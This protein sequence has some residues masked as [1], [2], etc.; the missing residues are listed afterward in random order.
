VL[1]A[2]AAFADSPMKTCSIDIQAASEKESEV[3]QVLA[4]FKTREKVLDDK[5]KKARTTLEPKIAAL[6][7]L[8]PEARAAEEAK[9]SGEINKLQEEFTKEA[10]KIKAD[11]E[12]VLKDM[13]EKNRLLAISFAKEHGCDELHT[14]IVP[15]AI[16]D[17]AKK[18]HLTNEFVTKYNKTYPAKAAPKTP[19]P[20]APPTKK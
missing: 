18:N 5:Q 20:K 13:R 7:N 4:D 11:F 15:I 1:N 2:S 3:Q 16:S 17:R 9:L 19:A 8:K 14:D 6:Q 12:A 10:D